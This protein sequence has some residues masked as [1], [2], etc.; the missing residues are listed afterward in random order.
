MKQLFDKK[1]WYVFSIDDLTDPDSE[2]S[3]IN[4]YCLQAGADSK[5][6]IPYLISNGIPMMIG[7]DDWGGH[8][9][10]IIGYDDMGTSGTQD[11]VLILADSYDTTDHEQDGY[12]VKSFERLVFGWNV[13]F[14]TWNDKWGSGQDY[15][16]FI[17]AFPRTAKYE[18]VAKELGVK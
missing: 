17:V 8:W 12:V 2:E 7:S 6:L 9:Q 16:N 5:G 4:G 3:Y 14:E 11:D 1:D 10:T 13:Q 15:N 18:N